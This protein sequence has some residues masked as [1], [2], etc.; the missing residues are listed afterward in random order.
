MEIT[1]MMNSTEKL[2][3]YE[4][5][6]RAHHL[7]IGVILIVI[8]VIPMTFFAN[9]EVMQYYQNLVIPGLPDAVSLVLAPMTIVLFC[10][11]FHGFEFSFDFVER[12]LTV[13]TFFFRAVKGRTRRY[14]FADIRKV[15]VFKDGNGANDLAKMQMTNGTRYSLMGNDTVEAA[16]QMKKMIECEL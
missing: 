15:A 3:I 7:A 1:A 11:N 5:S 14:A 9:P 6:S 2:V 12:R 4:P 8:V 16:K 13:T 10:I